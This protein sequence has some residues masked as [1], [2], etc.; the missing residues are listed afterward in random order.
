MFGV[1]FRRWVLILSTTAL[2]VAVLS[3]EGETVSK[4]DKK[5]FLKEV[6]RL[7]NPSEKK[8]E[9]EAYINRNPD[10]P[11]SVIRIWH[12]AGPTENRAPS[13]RTQ[14]GRQNTDRAEDR[15]RTS[16]FTSTSRSSRCMTI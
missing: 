13:G 12:F 4:G 10:G 6:D 15:H 7:E 14:I 9:L 2:C 16:L 5:R 11:P 1:E 8:A 3:C